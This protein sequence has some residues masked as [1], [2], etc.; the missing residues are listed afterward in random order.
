MTIADEIYMSTANPESTESK[1]VKKSNRYSCDH[2][3][4]GVTNLRLYREIKASLIRTKNSMID[5][6][7]SSELDLDENL[8]L[9]AEVVSSYERMRLIYQHYIFEGDIPIELLP[10]DVDEDEEELDDDDIAERD[11]MEDEED[12]DEDEENRISYTQIQRMASE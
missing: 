6:I 4:R 8:Q 3:D 11:F 5:E 1:T 7:L 12:E 10:D 9:I 2:N